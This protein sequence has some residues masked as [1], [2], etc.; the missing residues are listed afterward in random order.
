MFQLFLC[1]VTNVVAKQLWDGCC[2]VSSV[3]ALQHPPQLHWSPLVPLTAWPGLAPMYTWVLVT[4]A[5]CHSLPHEASGSVGAGASVSQHS[6]VTVSR[7][8]GE[9]RFGG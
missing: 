2:C 1:N 3:P 7:A 8:C 6:L 5:L 9:S 4:W